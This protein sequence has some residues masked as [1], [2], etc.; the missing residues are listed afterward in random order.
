MRVSRLR[1]ALEMVGR[2]EPAVLVLL[3]AVGPL[4]DSS[5]YVILLYV[6]EYLTIRLI[7]SGVGGFGGSLPA[8]RVARGGVDGRLTM[9]IQI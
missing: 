5:K 9:I 1:L 8:E 2:L 3:L 6:L 4:P 7:C